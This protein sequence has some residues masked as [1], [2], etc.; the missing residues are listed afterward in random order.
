MG[1]N[2]RR[3]ARTKALLQS[4]YDIE[5]HS[6]T[7]ETS[8][9]AST[10]GRGTTRFADD[11][12]ANARAE[13]DV[14]SKTFD[15]ETYTHSIARERSAR[16]MRETYNVLVR[17]MRAIESASQMLVYDNYARCAKASTAARE[18]E[19]RARASSLTC[20][21]VKAIVAR[22]KEKSART[23]RA[24]SD[25]REV[26]EQLRGVRGLIR[27]MSVA[28]RATETLERFENGKGECDE[29]GMNEDVG[30]HA[31]AA[32]MTYTESRAVLEALGGEGS[33]SK[34]FAAAKK[35]CDAVIGRIV[36]R[37]K[38][39]AR[40]KAIGDGELASDE[41]AY[42]LS[43]DA[44][45]ELLDALRVSQDELVDDFLSSRAKRSRESLLAMRARAN[46][47]SAESE[48][49]T[50]KSLSVKEYMSTLNQSF[51]R[52]FHA[53][54]EAFGKL[55]PK[56]TYR[57]ALVKFTKESFAEYFGVIRDVFAP[58]IDESNCD[59]VSND[60]LLDAKQLMC[61]LGTMAADLSSVHRAI[62]EAALGDRAM[63]V[64][65]RTVRSRVNAAFTCLERD[66][67][68]GLDSAMLAASAMSTGDADAQTSNTS[69]LQ[70]FIA[71]CDTLLTSVQRLLND[72][73]S[74]MDERPILLSSWREEF[75]YMVQG[76]FTNLIHALVSRLIVGSAT[77]P[78]PEPNPTPLSTP[79][80]NSVA[81]LANEEVALAPTPPTF[82][83][84]CARLSA[85]LHTSATPHIAQ[86]LLKM[87][88]ASAALG[89]GF[90]V[91]STS[92]MCE[93]AANV[94]L[95]SYVERSSQRLSFMIR[96]SLTAVDWSKLREPR[97]VRPLANFIAEDLEAI[98]RECAQ[99]LDVGESAIS[100]ES[101][102][103]DEVFTPVRS[104]QSSVMCAVIKRAV[105]S[106]TECVRCQT[107]QTKFGFQQVSLDVQ[108]LADRV[109]VRFLPSGQFAFDARERSSIETLLTEL[110][111]AIRSRALDPTPMDKA[112]VN[113]IIAGKKL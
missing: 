28:L 36:E 8:S 32:I 41:S 14:N 6:E 63:E 56:E 1:V 93:S 50:S 70:C 64:I 86:A 16:E 66:L 65:E 107:F 90:D 38:A 73:E 12:E 80:A 84:V 77:K 89:G 31:R 53:A 45:L 103:I 29:K 30:A 55:F 81:K 18:L 106:Y 52:D 96:K 35:R 112:I 61:A 40:A 34:T 82:L 101:S 95:L 3:I 76:N 21:E 5:T 27:S 87:F 10:I 74:L 2:D 72:V 47:P 92:A 111:D 37:L 51:L 22:A 85:F 102:E 24:L 78:S 100:I 104:T 46:G 60:K 68:R 42:G 67:V 97:E 71:L 99:I 108:Y 33:T 4:Y 62:P 20:V 26:V 23:H 43:D 25:R 79:L 13:G 17:E 98:E 69:L 113:R 105:K 91:E 54:T 57:G 11:A 83:L 58:Q 15:A 59:N 75:A 19:G 88:P 94:L 49:S 48:T 109:L 7:D 39:R 9:K 44:C 110:R